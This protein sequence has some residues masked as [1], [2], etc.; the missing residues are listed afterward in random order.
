MKHGSSVS[1]SSTSSSFV[2]PL[3]ISHQIS[4]GLVDV[5]AG[6][7]S[8]RTNQ[9]VTVSRAG[10]LV[11]V[12]SSTS[13]TND[14]ESTNKSARSTFLITTTDRRLDYLDRKHTILGEVL[15]SSPDNN[16]AREMKIL[17]EINSLALKGGESIDGVPIRRI[18]VKVVALDV[19]DR[20]ERIDKQTISST[21]RQL[22]FD[23]L[24]ASYNQLAPDACPVIRVSATKVTHNYMLAPRSNTSRITN[25]IGSDNNDNDS[26]FLSSGDD[27]DD[28]DDGVTRNNV[29]DLKNI[30]QQ[31]KEVETKIKKRRDDETQKI[32]L[33]LIGQR[34]TFG[35]GGGLLDVA[36]PDNVLFVCKL[37][38]LTQDDDLAQCFSSFGKVL[39]CEIMRDKKTGRSLQ[40]AFVE[41]DSADACA[42]AFR[43]MDRV[44]ID[45]SRIHV[46]FSQSLGR[47]YWQNRG[48]QRRERES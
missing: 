19:P 10:L 7:S 16:K 41:F 31:L 32:I 18:H 9:R 28:D 3:E 20:L 24:I 45:N 8:T 48:G 13:D 5:A 37:N 17:R 29:D 4:G 21:Y 11:M 6:A 38:P 33:Q 35:D 39:S 40:Y 30:E 43:K 12:T 2:V 42:A 22:F 23:K 46:D 47:V 36:P 1:L 34:P 27:D 25:I 14:S 15:F 26:Y 44:S